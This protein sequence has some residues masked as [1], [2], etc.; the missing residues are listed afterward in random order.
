MS[1]FRKLSTVEYSYLG[2]DTGQESPFVNQF[3]IEG[4][5]TISKQQL[6]NAVAIAHQNNPGISLTLKGRW[7]WRYWAKNPSPPQVLEYDGLWQGNNSDNKEVI[8]KAFNAREDILASI[9]LFTNI[10]SEPSLD[11]NSISENNINFK[12]LFR[13]HHAICD[14]LATLHWIEE[15]FRA[16]RNEPNLGSNCRLNETDIIYREEYPI[17][18]NLKTESKPVFPRSI[19]PDTQGSHWI[20]YRWQTKDTKIVAK[21]IYILKEFANKEHSQGKTTF[22]IPADLRRYLSKEEKNIAQLSNLSGFFD[23]HVDDDATINEIQ[24]LII[25]SMRE[26]KDLSVY[27]K[28]LVKFMKF[29]PNNI[30]MPNRDFLKNMHASGLCNITAMISYPGKANL[31]AYS[32]ETFQAKGLYGIPMPLEDKSIYVGM[33]TDENGVLAV[34]CVPN[35]LSNITN[36]EKLA[37]KVHNKLQSL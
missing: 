36:T 21:L 30:F 22:R 12:I 27:P 15:I 23:I 35:A 31:P 19:Y 34:L 9:T 14:G 11:N 5:G 16:L 32:C 18:E 3:F 37:E 7:A 17:A 24:N 25:K 8:D 29:L 28:K 2:R 20:K 33:V 1:K 13:I 10:K 4:C 6:E 26:K